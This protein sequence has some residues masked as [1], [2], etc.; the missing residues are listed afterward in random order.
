MSGCS[1]HLDDIELQI[2][3]RVQELG[4]LKDN[5]LKTDVCLRWVVSAK[6]FYNS[7]VGKSLGLSFIIDFL[8]LMRPLL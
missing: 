4:L 2:I 5:E 3:K 7:C 6:N 1:I 8:A